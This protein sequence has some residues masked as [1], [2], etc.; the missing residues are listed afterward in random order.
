MTSRSEGIPLVLMEAM[1]RGKPVLAPAITGIPELVIS[2]KT[3]FLYEPGSVENFVEL[4]LIIMYRIT[5]TGPGAG[6]WPLRGPLLLVGNHSS[7]LDPFWVTRVVPRHVQK[8]T[9]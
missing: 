3:G 9:W 5:F 7:Y 4:I 8:P 1:A 6:R 2:G